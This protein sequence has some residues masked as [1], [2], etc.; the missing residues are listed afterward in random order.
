MPPLLLIVFMGISSIIGTLSSTH[1]LFLNGIGKIRLQF[2]IQIIQAILFIPLVYALYI[3]GFGLTS[4]VIPGILFGI[5]GSI[6]FIMQYN[7]IISQ[8][9]K[10]IWNK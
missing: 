4:L 7:K 5:I 6:V 2:Y 3:I 10:G 1:T 9:A 8:N